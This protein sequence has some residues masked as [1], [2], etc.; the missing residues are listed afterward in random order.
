[1]IT[2]KIEQVFQ[3]IKKHIDVSVKHNKTLSCLLQ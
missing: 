2:S 1:M 3:D